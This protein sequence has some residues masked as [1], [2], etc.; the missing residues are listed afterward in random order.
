[1]KKKFFSKIDTSS[2]QN[3]HV[4]KVFTVGRFTVTV[5][6]VIAEGGFAIVFLVKAQNGNRYALKRM[7]VNNEQALNICKREI[8]ITRTLSGHRNIINFC[9]SSITM[10]PNKVYEVLILMQYCRGHVIQMM[11]ERINSGFSEKEVLRIFCDVC[12]AV[13][14]LH[15]CQTPIIHRDLKVENILVAD[16]G[17]Y[18]LCDFGSAT[19]RILNPGQGNVS[20][21]EEEIQ[22]YTTLSYRAPEMIDLYGGK[23]ITT[24]ADIWALGCML[25]KLCFFTLPFGESALAIQSGNFTV[26]DS[27]RYSKE[28]HALIGYMLTVDPDRR[29]DIHQVTNL[30]CKLASRECTVPN[31]NSVA[32]PDIRELP[33]PLTESEARQVKPTAYKT[34]TTPTIES[35][36]VVPRQRPKAQNIN[37]AN[38]L[39]LTN[40]TSVSARKRTT[41]S[42]QQTQAVK[43][44]QDFSQFFPL[45]NYFLFLFSENSLPPA[46]QNSQQSQQQISYQKQQLYQQ[47]IYNQQQQAS[48][49]S[50]VTNKLYNQQLYNLPAQTQQQYA[51]QQAAN[52]PPALNVPSANVMS[53]SYHGTTSQAP[54]TTSSQSMENLFSS[55]F[56]EPFHADPSNKVTVS[57]LIQLDDKL[58]VEQMDGQISFRKPAPPQKHKDKNSDSQPLIAI[59]PPSSPRAHAH[60]GHRR[61][62]SDT[63]FM[64]SH[65]KREQYPT[66]HTMGGKGSAFRAY[67]GTS[68]LLGPSFDQKSKSANTSPAQSPTRS[69]IIRPV[70]ASLTDWNP[71]GETFGADTEE[72]IFGKEFDRIRRGSITSISNVKSRE[73]LVMSGSDSSDPFTNAPF[74]K[75]GGRSYCSSSDSD[76]FDGRSAG[77]AQ[78]GFGDDDNG[79]KVADDED[80]LNNSQSSSKSH[81]F[82]ERTSFVAALRS[83]K[84]KQLVDNGTDDE[85]EVQTKATKAIPSRPDIKPELAESSSSYAEDDHPGLHFEK[86]SKDFSYQ[87]LDDEYGS[88][89]VA[90]SGSSR[91]T[92]MLVENVS[93]PEATA[94]KVG[95]KVAGA[96][97]VHSVGQMT[98]R[99]MGHEYGVR[100]LLDDDELEDSYG[101]VH[102]VPKQVES[103]DDRTSSSNSTTSPRA[104]LSPAMSP[105]VSSHSSDVFSAAPFHRKCSKKKRPISEIVQGSVGNKLISEM[106]PGGVQQAE[107]DIFASAPFKTKFR[108]KKGQSSQVT[109]TTS[110]LDFDNVE[111][112]DDGNFNINDVFG[113]APFIRKSSG[114]AKFPDSS[115]EPS[116]LSGSPLVDMQ[117]QQTTM[118]NVQNFSPA[119]EITTMHNKQAFSPSSDTRKTID[120]E[121][122]T[123]VSPLTESS[124]DHQPQGSSQDPFGAVPFRNVRIKQ[125]KER[126]FSGGNQ[127]LL[128]SSTPDKRFQQ[129]MQMTSQNI[130]ASMEQLEN[131]D[132]NFSP[133]HQKPEDLLLDHD[134]P[135]I[136]DEQDSF[137]SSGGAKHSKSHMWSRKTSRDI[138]ESAFSNMSF[139]D[140]DEYGDCAGMAEVEGGQFYKP[141]SSQ[142]NLKHSQSLH[143]S[144]IRHPAFAKETSPPAVAN[145]STE[146]MKIS[147]GGYDNYTWPRKQGRQLVTATMEPF[148]CDKN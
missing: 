116:P 28:L 3:P 22:K 78:S 11:N 136:D 126:H 60:R 143:I 106:I 56:N 81:D 57:Q 82:F 5:E 42:N 53:H 33:V 145:A 95:S 93:C 32:V 14:R 98:D 23:P 107:G 97:E 117:Y 92:E 83:S 20:Q 54:V 130:S 103:I 43:V 10:A 101:G 18:V 24:K 30:A 44:E 121:I 111:G 67:A 12:Q 124:S 65:R 86:M 123:N 17:H 73:D 99:I 91:K 4:G 55:T 135:G 8:H 63:A 122:R 16:N 118:H 59:T 36:S 142:N 46:Q 6:D 119:P 35:T 48:T 96:A 132:P 34:V 88:R 76:Q 62:V 68:N 50:G 45:S 105:S 70:S 109:V 84:Y 25:Y 66:I 7:F 104:G 52:Q 27:S 144:S 85:K 72:E 113:N 29:P 21:I 19:A 74:G 77:S 9:D 146:A 141:K 13:S 87:E 79:D 31:M 37:Q 51:Q 71:F 127:P 58:S 112:S 125:K 133:K 147:S 138:T 128:M 148:H 115:A 139:N 131:F 114:T 75:K 1:M 89:P 69:D 100:P 47:Q 15:H 140:D 2:Q 49:N 39:G 90:K 110:L 61:N 40:I 129:Q 38:T 41:A 64:N 80:N 137:N 108:S 102:N 134:E 26:P 94:S 120:M